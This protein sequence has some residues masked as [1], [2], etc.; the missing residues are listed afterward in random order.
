MRIIYDEQAVTVTIESVL[1]FSITVLLL[2]MVM[3][4]F[5]SINDQA[6]ETVMREQYGSIGND[7]AT[8]ILDLDIEV[9]A[10]LSQGSVV[11]IENQLNLKYLVA[12]KPYSI[13]LD[14]GKVI[15]QSVGSP[16]VTIEV[17]FDQ[18]VNVVP[19]S[20][21][22]STAAEHVMVYDAN[23]QIMFKNGGV[24]ATVDS[25]WPLIYFESPEAMSTLSGIETINVF[26]LDDIEIAKVEYYIDQNYETTTS[27]DWEW[28]TETI[29]DGYYTITA[30][31][32]DRAGHYSYDTRTFKVDN[33]LDIEAPTAEVVSPSDGENTDFNPPPIEV[34]VRDNIAI[35]NDTIK[36][37]FDGIDITANAT[38]TNT[39]LREYNIKY[40]PSAPLSLKTYQ[41]SIYAE[42]MF[43]GKGDPLNQ[44]VS[45]NWS[46]KIINNSDTTDP[47][48][49]I[50][51]PQTYMDLNTGDNIKVSY[52]ASDSSTGDS[53]IDYLLMNVSDGTSL[54]TH[55][56]NVSTYPDIVYSVTTTKT[57]PQKYVES[58][59]YT[60]NVTVFDRS[61]RS[62]VTQKGPFQ[63]NVSQASKVV[64]SVNATINAFTVTFDIR[65]SDTSSVVL[66]GMNVTSPAGGNLEKIR[67]GNSNV[68][69]GTLASPA[70]AEFNYPN[71]ETSDILVTLTFS[72]KPVQQVV[73]TIN[74]EDG[75]SKTVYT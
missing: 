6:S 3:L 21:I 49:S 19:G 36:L 60:Y 68:W 61:G 64:A 23:G 29:S 71:I 14:V 10:S 44:N 75:S 45:L 67:I 41:V 37:M 56:E 65:K 48:V 20:T 8:K 13:K 22:Y 26:T 55:R 73:I 53:G 39:S 31:A 52:I 63:I 18:R 50:S 1:L 9:K 38:I 72:V 2:G 32:Y 69:T 70:N 54:Y 15:V 59:I 25:Q 43:Y 35:D 30:M 40:T 12:R 62:Y 58:K 17:P 27:S 51:F 57:F 47:E 42:E 46:F 7:V 28:N 66:T 5:Q 34:I 74:F 33:G 11:G 16:S 24:D 4:S